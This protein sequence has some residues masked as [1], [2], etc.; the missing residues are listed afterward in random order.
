MDRFSRLRLT[1][2]VLA[3]LA[4]AACAEEPAPSPGAASTPAETTAG[5]TAD[6]AQQPRP[7]ATPDDS[8]TVAQAIEEEETAGEPAGESADE[9]IRLAQNETSGADGNARFKEGK[10]YRVLPVAQP[11]SVPPDKIEVVEVFWYGCP[12][13]YSIEPY[14]EQWRADKPANVEFVRIPAALN[15][16]WQLHARV[17]YTAEALG[18]LDEVHADLFRE[19]HAKGNRLMTEDSLIEFFGRYGVSE[20]QFTETL[21]SFAVQTKLRQADSLVRRYRITGVPAIV[22]NGKYV[23]GADLAG[24]EKQLFEVV[25][26][27]VAKESS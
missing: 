9:P 21:N 2:L 10:H 1:G 8:E 16:N 11:T 4:I 24:G 26:F 23:T 5:T 22:V 20:Q 6:A 27:L 13:C 7:A 15:R 17:F 3:A 19:M 12:H 14:V 18:V 25:D